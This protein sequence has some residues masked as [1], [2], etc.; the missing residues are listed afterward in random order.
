M[1]ITPSLDLSI[2]E[3]LNCIWEDL[4][5]DVQFVWNAVHGCVDSTAQVPLD[6]AGAVQTLHH[7]ACMQV[8]VHDV[9]GVHVRNP[10]TESLQS[11]NHLPDSQPA[12]S[13]TC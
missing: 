1:L 3:A 4:H 8:L 5:A 7:I 10:S 2:Q 9:V 13:S 6:P 11:H 12:Q